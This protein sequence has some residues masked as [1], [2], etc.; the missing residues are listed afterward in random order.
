MNSQLTIYTY[1]A[2]RLKEFNK[3]KS[4]KD[5]IIT[6]LALL[7]EENSIKFEEDK[8]IFIDIT[9]FYR[10]I[11]ESNPLS[12]E[13]IIYQIS[14]NNNFYI[15]INTNSLRRFKE[16]FGQFIEK[17]IPI[18][19]IYKKEDIV[20]DF[21]NLSNEQIQLL[22]QNLNTMLYGHKEFKKDLIQQIK[23]YSI[24][25][26]LK[27]IKI[28]SLLICGESGTGKTEVAR[29][30]HNTFYKD[31]NMIKINLGNYKTQGA[32]NSLIGSPKGY[33]GS[34]RGGELSNKIKN[35]DSKIILID[36]FEKADSDIFNF[37]YELLEDGKFT[38]LN[39]NE[40]DL[41]GYLIIFT[42]N[43]NDDN[44]KNIIPAPLLSRFT[45]K[46]L[47]EPVSFEEKSKYVRDR[48]KKLVKKYNE[49]YD[50]NMDYKSVLAKINNKDIKSIKNF[51]YLNRIIQ[52]ALIKEIEEKENENE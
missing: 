29:V 36:E 39:E 46:T 41:N 3:I 45:M 14:K 23:N 11:Q 10:S 22:E 32:L 18:N 12:V 33:L 26:K 6:A 21:S 51:R 9:N 2:D 7:D 25:Y 52:L 30:I 1:T 49:E 35:S 48:S 28:M 20:F 44:Y 17:E 37:F 16:D 15:L 50:G 24:L 5:I 4:E 40:Y 19:N 13:K 47:F 38:D 42:S 27:E 31:T 43:L 8:R 34:E